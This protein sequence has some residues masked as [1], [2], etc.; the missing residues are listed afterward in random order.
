[1]AGAVRDAS[2]VPHMTNSN[3]IM[4]PT[5]TSQTKV[6]EP[7]PEPESIPAA[8]QDFD[9]FVDNEVAA[10]VD[11]ST[12]V[13]SLVEEQAQSVQQAFKAER[14]FLLMSTKAKKPEPMRPDLFAD[15]HRFMSQVDE[16]KDTNRGSEYFK[17][18]AAV[19][20][21]IVALGWIMETRPADFVDSA[22][23]GAQYNG[24]TVLRTYKEK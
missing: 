12:K 16:I 23:S 15:I 6:H 14:M 10:F 17:H 2:P 1:M 19:S 18:L 8:I 21:G 13:G 4:T 11:L 24:N 22:L 7:A 3:A 5:P 20:E 9:E